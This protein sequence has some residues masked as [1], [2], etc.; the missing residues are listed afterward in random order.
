MVEQTL[1]SMSLTRLDIRTI[2]YVDDSSFSY[3]V[4][5]RHSHTMH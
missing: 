3:N 5:R 2:G 4:A 1:V